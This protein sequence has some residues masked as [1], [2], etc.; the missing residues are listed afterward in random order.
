MAHRMPLSQV[1]FGYFILPTIVYN[2]IAIHRHCQFLAKTIYICH[3][4]TA[5]GHC[6]IFTLRYIMIFIYLACIKCFVAYILTVCFR[7]AS[8]VLR[9]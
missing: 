7:I 5:T 1:T 8:S 6:N 2:S 9:G 3:V 4:E